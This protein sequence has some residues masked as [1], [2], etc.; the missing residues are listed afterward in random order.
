MTWQRLIRFED[1]SGQE[2]FGEPLIGKSEELQ[3]FLQSGTLS[4]RAL[5]GTGPFALSRT[6]EVYEVKRLL[7]IL[8][9]GDVPIIK[10]IGLNYMKHSKHISSLAGAG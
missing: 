6:Q 4:A 1:E 5:S 7:E 8:K 10:C 3:A 2:R 9:V